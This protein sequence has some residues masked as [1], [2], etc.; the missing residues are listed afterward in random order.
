MGNAVRWGTMYNYWFETDAAPTNGSVSTE[1]FKSNDTLSFAAIVP[2]A[3]TTCAADMNGDGVLDFFGVS[4]FLTAY[5]NEDTAAD[6]N[7][8]GLFDFFDISG[9][10]TAFSAGCPE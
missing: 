7:D 8:D 1:A 6:F 10:L 4:R 5:G 9:F 2:T 3:G